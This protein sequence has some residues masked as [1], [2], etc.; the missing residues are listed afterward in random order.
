MAVYI[1]A[2]G[3]VVLTI[4]VNATEMSRYLTVDNEPSSAVMVINVENW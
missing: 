2:G 4:P 3:R 1:V